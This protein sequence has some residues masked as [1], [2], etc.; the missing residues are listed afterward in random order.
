VKTLRSPKPVVHVSSSQRACRV[1]RKKLAQLAAFVAKA[2]GL[3]LAECGIAVVEGRTISRLNRHY[4][5]RA[6]TTDVL[7]FDLSDSPGGISAEIVLCGEAAVRQASLLGCS[8]QRELMLYLVHGLLH[9]MGYEDSSVRGAA[10]IS[11][12][13]EELLRLF[14]ARAT[15]KRTARRG[16]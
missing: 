11:A 1:P 8:P 10:K 6:G 9:L 2:E 15:G 13:Q 4:L 16:K 5:H 7:S 14:L 12:R 3:R